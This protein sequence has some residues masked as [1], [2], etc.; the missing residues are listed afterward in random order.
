MNKILYFILFQLTAAIT[1]AQDCK[2]KGTVLNE[3]GIPVTDASVSVFDAKNE[4]KG[5]VFTNSSGEFE[6]TLPC[7]QPYEIEIEQSGYETLVKKIEL[8][9]NK[10]EKLKLVKGTES[11]SLQ[12][13]IIKAQQAIKIKGDTV[14]YDADSFKVGNEEVL[15][16]ILKKLPG[17]E[18]ENGKVYHKGKEITTITVGGREVLG[19]NTK[20][21]NKNLPSDAVSKI[22]LNTKFKSNP[23]ASSLQE[24]EQASLNIELKED[25]KSL[26]FGNATIGGDSK[27]HADAQLKA[28]YFSEKM[29][30][31][32]INDFNTYGKEVFD[33]EDYF[34][35]FG[36][37]S[38]FNAEGS[39]YSLR[40]GSS[41]LNF[42]SNTNAAEMNTYNGAAHF[43]YEPNKKLKLSGFGLVNT[44]NIRYNSKIERYYNTLE[45]PFTE[46]DE[47]Q[48]E[49]KLIS[50]MS[51]LRL[52]YR[53]NDRGEFKYRINFNYTGNEDEQNVNRFRNNESVGYNT[54]LTDRKNFSL[55]QSLSYIQ[56]IGRDHNIGFYVRHQYQKETPDL[57]MNAEEP[58]FNIFG[59]LTNIG[60]RYILSQNQ[61]YITNT[62]QLYSVYNHLIN[63]TTNLKLKV[64]T[65]FSVQDF[66]NKIYD[67]GNLI[68]QAVNGVNTISNTDFD[69]NET[70]ADATITKKIGK[71]QADLGAGVS[72]FNEKVNYYNSPSVKFNETEILPHANLRYNFNNAT[73]I[74]FNYNKGYSFP[75]AKDLTESYTLQS[76]R[77][78]FAGNQDLRQALTHTSS[79]GFNHFNSFSFFNVF[80]N[81]SYTQRDR[82]I[83]TASQFERVATDPNNPDA[84]TISQINT[85]LNSEYDDKTYAA[86]LNVSKRFKKWYNVRFNGNVSYSDNFTY[87]NTITEPELQTVN[88]K[89]LSQNYTLTNTFTFKKRLE[90]KAGLNASFSKFES[91]VSQEFETWR[92][93]G[94]VAWSITDKLLLQSDF[95]YRIQNRDGSRINE[96]KEL[97]A[98][99]RYNAFKKTYISF[100]AG[101]ILGNN[102][103]VSNSFNNNYVQ[104]STTD[105]LGRY[106]IVNLRYKF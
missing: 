66:E 35:F 95:S 44:N 86:N 92:P 90:L 12:E 73:S 7:N 71:F 29:D 16:D 101:N 103:I 94:D 88:N 87:T 48:N 53:P 55:S 69:Y 68:T 2:L 9:G 19:G 22:Q 72:F 18:V 79:L 100:I 65:N 38:E 76:Y 23:F 14:E 10:N 49:N 4:G 105:V 17:I 6:F 104:T 39:I 61:N 91:L 27:D 37:F 41:A 32:V 81:L 64:G 82:S 99:I 57:L 30:A 46:V 15:E 45:T 74:F 33:R 31:T 60:G 52:D 96:A 26:L 24:D 51:R 13:T 20:L 56:K 80:A 47:Q 93:F 43:G 42:G 1:F 83:Q 67:Q 34:S 40:G 75:H 63:N 62:I 3:M 89:S 8:D 5:F 98:S 36:G 70:F 54:N 97:N 85:L 106:F 28:F 58:M 78:I 59:N 84:F 77:S 50:A 11:I 25:A 21:L 102:V